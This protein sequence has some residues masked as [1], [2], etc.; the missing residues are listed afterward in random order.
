MR[1]THTRESSAAPSVKAPA[2][3]RRAKKGKAEK[4]KTP[5]L[6]APLSVL[7]KD[8]TNIPVKDMEG[9]V[10]RTEDVRKKEVEKR[11]GYVTRPMNSFMLYRSAYAERTKQWCLQNNHQIVSSVSGESWPLEPQ[12]LRDHYNELAKTERTNHQKAHPTYKFSPSKPGSAN[13]KRKGTDS[14]DE[15]LSDMDDPDGDWG[16]THGRSRNKRN[17][18][19]E[20]SSSPFRPANSSPYHPELAWNSPIFSPDN[21]MHR[22]AW[23]MTNQGKPLPQAI[24]DGLAYNQ[25]WHQ[26]APM[27]PNPMPSRPEDVR[28]R[29]VDSPL[30]P[31]YSLGQSLIGVPGGEHHELFQVHSHSGTPIPQEVQV[32]PTLLEFDHERFGEANGVGAVDHAID[33]FQL[34]TET[35]GH[36]LD[37]TLSSDLNDHRGHADDDE[38]LGA[39]SEFDRLMAEGHAS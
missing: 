9:W 2:K 11:K 6:N 35:A 14:D 27:Y 39:H 3:S 7:T 8:M 31:S 24:P 26:T 5:K 30:V 1:P 29:P 22:S 20:T 15:D 4:P 17:R 33:P 36:G 13:R 18:T 19:Q 32:D 12:E 16:A 37:T 10:N 21:G 28:M 34:G 25:F 23:D 38:L